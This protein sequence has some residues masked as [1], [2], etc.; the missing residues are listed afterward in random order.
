MLIHRLGNDIA[1]SSRFT[2]DAMKRTKRLSIEFR[3]REITITATGSTL[4]VQDSE[5]DAANTP[6]VCPTCGSPWITIVARVD[7][8]VP[9]NTDLIHRALQQ[10]GL[11][12]QVSPAGQ[13]RICQRSF[14]ELKES[15]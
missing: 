15:L 5:P 7:G 8:E 11:H 4:H 13:L 1:S 3:H 14:E 9:A 2:E 6:A 12:L 10:S